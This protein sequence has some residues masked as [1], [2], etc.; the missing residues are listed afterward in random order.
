MPALSIHK[1][2]KSNP[3]YIH[4]WTGF[5]DI[6][7][8]FYGK[9][10]SF[11]GYLQVE[12]LYIQAIQDIL[13]VLQIN[14]LSICYCR[15]S[16]S[17]KNTKTDA[18]LTPEQYLL[19][20]RIDDGMLLNRSEISDVV[21]LN[22]RGTLGCRLVG[23]NIN[24]HFGYDYYM[25]VEMSSKAYFK[26]LQQIITAA[27]LY[28]QEFP[29]APYHLDKEDVDALS[30]RWSNGQTNPPGDYHHDLRISKDNPQNRTYTEWS[31]FDEIGHGLDWEKYQATEQ[32]YLQ[33]VLDF[34]EIFQVNQLAVN[35]GL[36]FTT[37]QELGVPA[38]YFSPQEEALFQQ[39]Q[40]YDETVEDWTIEAFI[41]PK[42]DFATLFQLIFK[43][44]LRTWISTDLLTIQ[45]DSSYRLYLSFY[46]HKKEIQQLVE[47]QSL[48]WQERQPPYHETVD[49]S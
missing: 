18:A 13:D 10:L 28:W 31:H 15:K 6:G 26:E 16:D 41:I 47:K 36:G 39:L 38:H 43:G 24:I 40:E 22:L 48:Y 21:R 32:K 49:F 4:D 35:G 2:D 29:I 25:Y 12:N 45:F 46:G 11:E 23:N 19:Y 3:N 8:Q 33:L 30:F 20:Q 34:L 9:L 14:N 5:Y 42:E 37:I 27:G 44:R 17:R 1:Y 7:Q